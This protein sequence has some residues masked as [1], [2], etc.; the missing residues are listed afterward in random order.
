MPGAKDGERPLDS[1][2][3]RIAANYAVIEEKVAAAGGRNRTRIVAVTKTH[4]ADVV[5]AALM[6]GLGDFGENYAHELIS[7]AEAVGG[8]EVRWHMIGHIQS[9]AIKGLAPHVAV[10]HSV[11]RAKELDILSHL[12]VRAKVLVQVDY[13]GVEGRNGVAPAQVPELVDHGRRLGLDLA[14]LMVVTPLIEVAGRARIFAATRELG[15]SVGLGEFSMGM[16]DDF[17]WAVREGSTMVRIGRAIFGD[18]PA[19]QPAEVR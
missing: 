7:K 6:A 13:T 19:A 1:L 15:E 2:A 11:S 16:T 10:W 5:R 14:G 9:R 18:R 12:G 17:E 4:P 3:E 8:S